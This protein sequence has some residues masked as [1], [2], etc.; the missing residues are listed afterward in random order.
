VIGEVAAGCSAGNTVGHDLVVQNNAGPID[1]GNDN[2]R[3]DLT[4]Q[5]NKPGSATIRNDSA[6]HTAT[7]QKNS[8]QS[9][10]R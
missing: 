5:G 4:V 2:V 6:G 7:C 1:V 8:P 3:H 9:L 10:G